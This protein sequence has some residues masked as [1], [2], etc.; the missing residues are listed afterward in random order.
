MRKAEIEQ[1]VTGNVVFQQPKGFEEVVCNLCRHDSYDVVLKQ[2]LTE[3]DVALFSEKGIPPEDTSIKTL[4]IVRCR[5]C[6]LCYANPRPVADLLHLWY[7]LATG[8]P[9]LQEPSRKMRS[10]ASYLKRLRSLAPGNRL[11]DV[12]CY[13]GFFLKAAHESGWDVQG[14]EPSDW[15]SRYVR[16]IL[17]LPVVTTTL[18]EVSFKEESFD[19]ITLFQVLEHVLDPR[20][21]LTRLQR[22]LVRGGVLALSVPDIHTPFAR[23]LKEKSWLLR[24][25][26]LYYFSPKT[27]S[28]YLDQTGFEPIWKGTAVNV[29]NLSYVAEHLK[30]YLGKLATVFYKTLYFLR[31]D[32]VGIQVD[33][34]DLLLMYAR[35][36]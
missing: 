12:G 14:V 15:A 1:G 10:T 34:G 21:F 31:L 9:C 33:L 32:R 28:A 4:R 25:C 7:R 11:L 20:E 35:K 6:G 24:P 2:T 36:K 16:E 26:H 8:I 5:E 30:P 29:F 23:V 3:N 27:L 18:E 17:H 19:A 13:T 22:L